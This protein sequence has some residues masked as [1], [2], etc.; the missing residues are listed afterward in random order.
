MKYEDLIVG[1]S[2]LSHNDLFTADYDEVAALV[3][4]AIFPCVH[5]VVLV[6]LVELAKL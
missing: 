2:L 1:H 6:E 4:L 5:S 3:I